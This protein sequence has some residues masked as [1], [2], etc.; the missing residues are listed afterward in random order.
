MRKMQRMTNKLKLLARFAF[1]FSLA[2]SRFCP[3]SASFLTLESVL[4]STE[5]FHPQ[6][7]KAQQEVQEQERL[8][9]ARR[10]PFDLRL[11]AEYGEHSGYPEVKFQEY[12][13]E[14]TLPW[15][16]IKVKGGFDVASGLFPTYS[17]DR[18][19]GRFKGAITIPILR[20]LVTDRARTELQNQKLRAE[21]QLQ[22]E[23]LAK[24]ETY[25][26]AAV[27][28]WSWR[29]RVENRRVIEDLLKLALETDSFIELRVK[30]GDAP[31]ID[32]VENQKIIAQRKA[33]LVSA[34]QTESDAALRLSLFLR[35]DEANRI[36]PQ[37]TQADIWTKEVLP[38]DLIPELNVN[39]VVE[40]FP[41]V[42]QL[43]QDIEILKISR[44]LQAQNQLPQ[45]DFK[46]EDSTY[47]GSLPGDRTDAR[48]QFAGLS[49]SV[50]L[51]NLEARNQK[52]ALDF[53]IEARLNDLRL[54]KEQ[55]SN[56]IHQT[57]IDVRALEDVLR[58]NQIEL[59]TSDELVVAER[60]RFK[61]GGSS[62]FLVYA[63]ESEAV[64]AKIKV[65]DALLRLKSKYVELQLF[66]NE[67]IKKY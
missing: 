53:R 33:Q 26:Q 8:V 62:L 7:L 11:S 63:R 30:K 46:Y 32:K 14:T 42:Q 25:S 43:N 29:S 23:K 37:A 28:Y 17:G 41:S 39:D 9:A 19:T 18:N 10:A 13:L 57:I 36:I 34:K 52:R 64:L 49:F 65:H 4:D 2:L 35:E 22:L 15:T 40:S 67:W 66:K 27:A 31:K 3:A 58:N 55:L 12:G 50:P 47:N 38:K 61:A 1:I 48:E 44:R 20:D 51:L 45:L 59:K 6:I 21:L 24:I 16:G 56:Q 54:R 5:K 60:S